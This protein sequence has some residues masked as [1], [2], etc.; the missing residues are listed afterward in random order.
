MKSRIGK[1]FGLAV[2]AALFSILAGG[3]L[4]WLAIAQDTLTEDITAQIEAAAYDP[5]MAAGVVR[6][7]VANTPHQAAAIVRSAVQAA[8]H[9]STTLIAAAVVPAR[10]QLAPMQQ[11]ATDAAPKQANVIAIAAAIASKVVAHPE[12]DTAIV[13]AAI[14]ETPGQS[15]AVVTAAATVCRFVE[16]CSPIS[17]MPLVQA[18]VIADLQ[19]TEGIVEA[20]VSLFPASAGEIIAAATQSSLSARTAQQGRV[21]AVPQLAPV[22][23]PAPAVPGLQEPVIVADNS[24]EPG[25]ADVVVPPAPV[26]TEF[27]DPTS[28]GTGDGTGTGDDEDDDD[29][30]DEGTGTGTGT[31]TPVIPPLPPVFPASPF[32]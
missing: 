12:Q 9:L 1:R 31:G 32:F 5:D 4:F 10:D 27:P 17:P 22:A 14:R 28:S 30:D 7:A 6:D 15:K 21:T 13:S 2:W 3:S 25:A 24:P 11:A 19:A 8:P 29:D 26:P 23:N 20:T 18:A 16:G